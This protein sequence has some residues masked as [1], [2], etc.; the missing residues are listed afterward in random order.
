L[1][2]QLETAQV[3]TVIHADVFLQRVVKQRIA[4][5]RDVVR[6]VAVVKAIRHHEIH[7]VLRPRPGIGGG[8]A[9]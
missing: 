5:R 3:A 6:R 8:E 4:A 7:H 1:D 9:E 2:R